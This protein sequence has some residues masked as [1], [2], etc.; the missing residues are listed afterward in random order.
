MKYFIVENGQQSGPFTIYEL[1]DKGITS[2]TLVWAEGMKDWQP[3]WQ[4]EE[5][6]NFLYGTQESQTPPPVPPTSTTETPQE[7]AQPAPKPK[8]H[9]GGI[10]TLG[11]IAL[12]LVVMAVSN[13]SKDEHEDTILNN[14]SNAISNTSSDADDYGTGILQEIASQMMKPFMSG[15]LTYH[16]YLFFSTTTIHLLDK[17]HRTS[18]GILGMVF[19]ADEEDVEKLINKSTKS[20]YQFNSNSIDEYND[21]G[22]D[23]Q[24][25]QSADSSEEELGKQ[26][27]SSV[28][29]YVKDKV[30]EETDSTTSSGI[31]KII[32]GIVSLVKGE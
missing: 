14:V 8:R 16:N 31:G 27:A 6:K 20:S 1:K 28:G 2:D 12:L 11:L 26:I 7:P 10:I 5:L 18:F 13:P 3:A 17:D 30:K 29:E 19:T 9:Y 24:S 15:A 25:A 4:V 22:S 23:D 21:D 32:D